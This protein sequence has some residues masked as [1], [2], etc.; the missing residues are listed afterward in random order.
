MLRG[1]RRDLSL[2]V[3]LLS[4][5]VTQSI[6]PFVLFIG[7][8]ILTSQWLETIRVDATQNMHSPLELFLDP[9]I[10][11]FQRS[12]PAWALLP[13]GFL[14]ILVSMWLFDRAIPPLQISSTRMGLIHHLLYR[15]IVTFLFGMLL[16]SVTLSVS[17][18][19]S[20]LVPLSVRGYIRRENVIPYILGA[21][22]T[23]FVDTLVAAAVLS[24]P[25]AVTIVIAQM[26][27]V[28]IVA[29]I[30]LLVFFH[31]YASLLDKL[32]H[33]L[34]SK[35]RYLLAYVIIILAIPFL[36]LIYG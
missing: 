6:Y 24:N 26:I 2:S 20:L 21:N 18:S 29:L 31:A 19:L 32:V 34:G 11:F 23:T 15:P 28:T 16:T 22:I 17:V 12:L 35:R 3:G 10:H 9:L 7:G 30:V 14:L 33:F 5:L 13:F 36:L 25:T 27:S 4:L 8:K 1:K